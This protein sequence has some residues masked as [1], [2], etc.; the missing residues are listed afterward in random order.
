MATSK[1]LFVYL[2]RPDT[3]D[4]PTGLRTLLSQRLMRALAVLS[5]R[6]LAFN[7]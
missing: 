3:G 2:Q 7:Y 6:P 1:P 5:A 4:L